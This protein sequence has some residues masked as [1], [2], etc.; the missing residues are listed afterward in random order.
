MAIARLRA[1]RCDWWIPLLLAVVVAVEVL[2]KLLIAQD[3]PPH[4]LSR[5]IQFLPFL[6]APTHYA[7]P[8]GHVA[9]MAFL[10]TALRWPS[11]AA[12]VLVL[13]MALT[14]V[15]LAEHWPSD[16]LG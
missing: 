5:S 7:F 16:V 12:M 13:V 14:R 4:E 8:S 11:V 10:V 2:G 15:Y 9:R 6:E 3:P 1:R